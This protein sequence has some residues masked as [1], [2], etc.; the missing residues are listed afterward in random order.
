MIG[1][2]GQNNQQQFGDSNHHQHGRG[3]QNQAVDPGPRPGAAG[4]GTTD[5]NEG[6]FPT[7]NSA[8]QALFFGGFTQFVEVEGVPQSPAG[9][10]GNGGLGPGFN[11]NSCGSCHTQPAILGSS[12]GPNSPQ[13][14]QTNP[15][16][17][18]ALLIQPRISFHP[19]L[20]LMDQYGKLDLSDTQMVRSM[21]RCITCFLLQDEQMRQVV[22]CPN[23]TLLVS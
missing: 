4:A 22:T 7:L 13:V 8:E 1:G 23:Q 2:W 14:P 3:P 5:G 20:R 12:P 9:T 17:V 6:Y 15:E 19:S 16:I 10:L 18:A 11:S 21:V